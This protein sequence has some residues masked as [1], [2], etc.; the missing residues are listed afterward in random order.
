MSPGRDLGPGEVLVND[1]WERFRIYQSRPKGIKDR[2]FRFERAKFED[3]WALKGISF[4]LTAGESFAVIGPNGSGKSTLLKCL[5][6]ILPSDRGEVLV[7]GKIASLLEL[8]AGFHGDLTGRE[9]VYLNGSILGLRRRQ[10]EKA[11]DEIVAFA[12]VEDFIDTPVR[13]YSSGMYV[14][15]GFS[16]AVHVDPDVLLIDEILAVGDAAFQTKCFERMHDF[17]RRGKTLILVTH[18]IDAAARLCDRAI[19]LE[20]GDVVEEGNARKVVDAY[21]RRVFGE[22]PQEV[23]E[24]PVRSD[25]WGTG[26]AEIVE[27]ELVDEAGSRVTWVPPGTTCTFRQLIRFKQEVEEPVFE[28]IVR[29]EDGTDIFT[30]NTMWREIKTGAYQAGDVVEVRF[31][32]RMNLLPGRYVF[33]SAVTH[34]DATQW[35]DWW[36]DCL[37]FQVRGSTLDKGYANLDADVEIRVASRAAI[38]ALTRDPGKR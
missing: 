2:L 17:K 15:L 16:V 38:S 18:D 37:F 14:R 6:G 3:F 21:R 30:L 19:L 28:Y 33:I 5:S 4:E 35:Y 32:Q 25:R 13:N 22:Q 27:V 36:N 11:F 9:N 23:A 1:L 31:R 26:E 34:R 29:S 10:L 7:G 20:R 8:G 24:E 12:G